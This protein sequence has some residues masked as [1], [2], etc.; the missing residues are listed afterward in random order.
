M[1]ELFSTVNGFN[2]GINNSELNGTKCVDCGYL[3]LPPRP[4]C[5]E[6]GSTNMV[7]Y[8]FKEEGVVRALTTETV[9]LSRFREMCPT[10]VGIIQLDEGPMISGVILEEEKIEVGS[11]VKATFIEDG[12]RKILGFK[13]V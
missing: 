10:T 11:M 1:M 2:E 8:K 3:M 5:T 9:P 13:P 7:S 12:E 6:C 4:L